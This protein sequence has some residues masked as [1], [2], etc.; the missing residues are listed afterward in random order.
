MGKEKERDADQ[1]QDKEASE[2]VNED[3]KHFMLLVMYER[4]KC[5][6]TLSTVSVQTQE[7]RCVH[8][9]GCEAVRV[10]ASF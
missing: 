7:P 4:A 1:S 10:R 9:C 8:H 3:L 2:K 5:S 6:S